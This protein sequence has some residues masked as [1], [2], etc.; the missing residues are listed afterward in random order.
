MISLVSFLVWSGMDNRP[1]RPLSE[2]VRLT[3]ISSLFQFDFVG[4]VTLMSL[5]AWSI[6]KRSIKYPI[7]EE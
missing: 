7:L 5:L 2:A 4:L 1:D 6:Y 3:L